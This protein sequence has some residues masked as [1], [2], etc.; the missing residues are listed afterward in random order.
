MTGARVNDQ[1]VGR[2]RIGA[3][4]RY[5]AVTVPCSGSPA[6][7]ESPVSV[8]S[9]R[10]SGRRYDATRKEPVTVFFQLP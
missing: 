4:N 6:I 9:T 5:R 8:T 10:K 3:P 2:F 7:F 1:W